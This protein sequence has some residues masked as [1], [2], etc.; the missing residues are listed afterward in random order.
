MHKRQFD[1]EG[2]GI[3]STIVALVV[4]ML[5]GV[6]LMTSLSAYAADTLTSTIRSNAGAVASRVIQ[7]ELVD[8]CGAVTG[9]ESST[10]AATLTTTCPNGLG[11][12][13]R[14]AQSAGFHYWVDFFSSW[15]PSTG[16][17]TSCSD[18]AGQTPVALLETVFVSWRSGGLY[19]QQMYTSMEPVPT[20]ALSYVSSQLG[21]IYVTGGG[22]LTTPSG[23]QVQRSGLSGTALA[24]YVS[25][26]NDPPNKTLSGSTP[27][28]VNPSGGCAWFPF[29]TPGTW[30]VSSSSTP[31]VS[32]TV[33]VTAGGT[34]SG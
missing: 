33:S 26:I 27:P 10:V 11:D 22:A 28:A 14:S 24:K 3:Y 34:V 6:I 32:S 7:T 2:Q 25:S 15:V 9:I 17:A 19:Q 5:L 12:F 29:L 16:L 20:V 31:P 13:A 18:Y 8:Q 4:M 21:A 30:T 1:E 23:A